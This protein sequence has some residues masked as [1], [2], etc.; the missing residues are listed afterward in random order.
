[1]A[2]FDF[3]D[4]F[5]EH[6]IL[7]DI[8]FTALSADFELLY[9]SFSMVL[10]FIKNFFRLYFRCGKCRR[11]FLIY[12]VSCIE[13]IKPSVVIT[14]FDNNYIFHAASQYYKKA[15]FYAVQNG[16]RYCGT[17]LKDAADEAS[18]FRITSSL[19]N[20]VCFGSH[21]VD[22]YQNI[23]R[24]VYDRFHPVGSLLGGYYWS[25]AKSRDIK[26]EYDIC[27][28]SQWRHQDVLE[29]HFPSHKKACETLN[30]HLLKF[31]NERKIS[32]CIA[33]ATRCKEE[34]EYFKT[35]FGSDTLVIPND[36]ERFSTY[37]AMNKSDVVLTLSSTAGY[38]ALGWGKKVLFCNYYG[39]SK[40]DPLA[41]GLN[42]LNEESYDEFRNRLDLL[43]KIDDIEYSRA[44]EKRRKYIMNYDFDMPAHNYVRKILLND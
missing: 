4:H 6:L 24:R 1:V 39:D 37:V 11:M 31:V 26:T 25:Q 8:Q 3:S 13:N 29:R 7:R 17:D 18:R 38:E 44:T 36:K 5:L 20:F 30:R 43:L 33:A 42:S 32:F 27:L 41:D 40:F 10:S 23:G 19:C 16:A 15:K 9:I 14:I 22:A 21:E 2:V 34:V 12:L 35:A 28:V